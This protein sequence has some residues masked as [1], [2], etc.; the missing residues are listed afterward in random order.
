MKN[1]N[2]ILA[3]IYTAFLTSHEKQE[4]VSGSILYITIPMRIPN[5]ID[6]TYP[7]NR[8]TPLSNLTLERISHGLTLLM[9]WTQFTLAYLS[10]SSN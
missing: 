7:T 8:L 2:C 1:P 5:K 9:P 6:I 10:S 3:S 4:V